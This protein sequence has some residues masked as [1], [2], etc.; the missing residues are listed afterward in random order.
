M[1]IN[2]FFQNGEYS[3]HAHSKSG[4]LGITLPYWDVSLDN[5]VIDAAKELSA[6]VPYQQDMNAG[7]PIGLGW[8]QSTVYNGVRTDSNTAYISKFLWRP[9]LTVLTNAQ[10][11]EI[12]KTGMLNSFPV[13]RGV[14]FSSNATGKKFR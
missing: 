13:F 9:N 3:P 8:T 11:T 14:E 10:V 2:S 12:L 4:L 1:A 5:R 7:N 6:E